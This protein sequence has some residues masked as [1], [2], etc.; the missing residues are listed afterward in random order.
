[1]VLAAGLGTRLRP[2]TND[3]PKALVEVAGHTMLAITLGRLRAFGIQDVIVNVHHYADMI[4]DYLK[5]NNNF[6]MHVEISREDTLLDTGGG[7]KKAAPFFLRDAASAQEPFLLHNVD[8]VSN[9]ELAAMLAAHQQSGALA[10][11][12]VQQ[13]ESS[14]LLL[15]DQTLQLRGRRVSGGQEGKDLQALAFAGIHILS[16]K[17]LGMMDEAAAFSIIDTY[18]RLA[19]DGEKIIGHR[20]DNAYWRDLGKPESV[21]RAA[22]DLAAHPALFL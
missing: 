19:A 6:A 18:L 4:V 5:A 1:M 17:L 3:R 11:L 2:L 10:T 20:D 12:A 16:P 14:R 7:L 9:W 15:F 22:T 13:R 21:A 8:I